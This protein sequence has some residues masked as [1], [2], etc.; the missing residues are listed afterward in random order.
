MYVGNWEYVQMKA[1]KLPEEVERAF[2][3][4]T[5]H[6]K[7]VTY[8]PVLYVARQVVVGMN[9]LLICKSLILTQPTRESCVEMLIYKPIGGPA[10]ITKVIDLTEV[11]S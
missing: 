5:G 3:E 2:E 10:Y 11:N 7:G 4:A 8:V 6:L 9:Y 1:C